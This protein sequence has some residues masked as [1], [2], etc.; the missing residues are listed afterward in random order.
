M[1]SEQ[2]LYYSGLRR[3]KGGKKKEERDDVLHVSSNV[4]QCE[5]QLII[6]LIRAKESAI[7]ST[8]CLLSTAHHKLLPFI[9]SV[10]DCASHRALVP[11]D[12]WSEI[13][14]HVLI[15]NYL[16]SK[17]RVISSLGRNTQLVFDVQLEARGGR[18]CSETWI[19]REYILCIIKFQPQ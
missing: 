7:Q 11:F 14:S 6:Q 2:E 3:R 5:V 4:A 10:G 13:Q 15:N 19:C 9:L 8:S 16:G 1:S 17:A 18:T 12:P